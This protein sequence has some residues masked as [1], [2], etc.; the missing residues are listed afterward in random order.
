M[1]CFTTGRGTVVGFKPVPCLKLAS[2]TPLYDRLSEDI[3]I[4]CGPVLDEGKTVKEMGRVIFQAILDAASGKPSC[5]EALGFGDR[6][7][8]PWHIGAVL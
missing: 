5:S 2:N 3:D 6:E 1:V 7:F 4:N 8:V